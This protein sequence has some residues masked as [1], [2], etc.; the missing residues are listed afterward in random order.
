MAAERSS[1]SVHRQGRRLRSLNK[2]LRTYM[3]SIEDGVHYAINFCST[4]IL[5]Y[6]RGLLHGDLRN[7][8]NEWDK[9]IPGFCQVHRDATS[10]FQRGE[11]TSNQANRCPACLLLGVEAQR[12]AWVKEAHLYLRQRWL[13][14]SATSE[15]SITVRRGVMRQQG[16]IWDQQ[17]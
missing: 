14:W 17:T 15:R 12:C 3:E 8:S 16:K 9:E 6:V 1:Y 5:R 4:W 2:V 11:H 10:N 7:A 13:A